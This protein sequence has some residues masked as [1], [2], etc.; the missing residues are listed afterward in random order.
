[1][2][3]GAAAIGGLAAARDDIKWYSDRERAW[4][5]HTSAWDRQKTA[6]Q[7]QIQWAV[8]D[9]KKAGLH[10]L[11]ALGVSPASAPVTHTVGG[12][13]GEEGTRQLGAALRQMGARP[14]K[15]YERQ[16]YESRELDLEYKNLRNDQLL[17]S[18]MGQAT[19]GPSGHDN[20]GRGSVPGQ[21]VDI[22]PDRPTAANPRS[23]GGLTAANHPAEMVT[24]V[25]NPRYG[26]VAIP[27]L[28]QALTESLEDN[29]MFKIPYYATKIDS[30]FQGFA[31]KYGQDPIAMKRW[32]DFW[33]ERL[34]DPGRGLEWGYHAAGYFYRQRK[35]TNARNARRRYETQ[36]S[37]RAIWADMPH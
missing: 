7:N 24:Y 12:F 14:S 17:M 2:F 22:Q 33:N 5:Y 1:M 10:P 20:L 32:N 31:A 37:E 29:L 18:N 25:E 16:E 21:E 28:T 19:L 15:E 35:G 13:R 6:M 11:A 3:A 4:K 34:P 30:Y 9:A 36:R 8:E 26:S 27:T 23:S